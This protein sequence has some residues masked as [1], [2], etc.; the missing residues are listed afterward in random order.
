MFIHYPSSILSACRLLLTDI[1]RTDSPKFHCV[2]QGA[3]K[4]PA[5]FQHILPEL[6]LDKGVWQICDRAIYGF[7]LVALS[8]GSWV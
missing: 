6:Y 1:E 5:A 3:F 2:Q 8:V 7:V 4:I